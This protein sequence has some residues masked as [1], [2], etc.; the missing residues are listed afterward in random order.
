ML[1]IYK[2]TCLAPKPYAVDVGN[3][4]WKNGVAEAAS[5]FSQYSEPQHPSASVWI[6]PGTE[7]S[8]NG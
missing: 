6:V 1:V 8:C 5:L 3:T 2:H 4:Q 7:E